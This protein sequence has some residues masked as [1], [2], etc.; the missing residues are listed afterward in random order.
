MRPMT[1]R[2]PMRQAATMGRPT[3]TPH[4]VTPTTV[5]QTTPVA[6]SIRTR[7]ARAL[8]ASPPRIPLVFRWPRP[9]L[10]TRAMDRRPSRP[11]RR[12]APRGA[13]R[14]RP[15]SRSRAC[16]DPTTVAADARRGTRA[17]R[18]R[19]WSSSPRSSRLG[20]AAGGPGPRLLC[21]E[22]RSTSPL[23]RR[24]PPAR[25]GGKRW[26]FRW[27]GSSHRT[28]S[29]KRTRSSRRSEPA[30]GRGSR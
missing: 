25:V 30:P 12:S 29:Q 15:P 11:G 2:G 21:K 6:P 17:N 13:V 18:V 1:R 7:G 23:K 16:S 28:L 19:W 4:R 3:K 10:P 27:T 20:A 8:R 22:Y 14:P 9:A 5:A 26:R 24:R